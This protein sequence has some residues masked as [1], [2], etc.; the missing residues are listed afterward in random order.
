LVTAAESTV[1]E[2]SAAAPQLVYPLSSEEIARAKA[3]ETAHMAELL[4]QPGVQGVGISSS[5]DSAGE[6]ALLIYFIRGVEHG[7]VPQ[8]IDG[9]RTRVREGSRFRGDYGG[10]RPKRGCSVPA[11]KTAQAGT[12]SIT[13][14]KL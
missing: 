7:A 14:P 13:K 11:P 5:A 9:L 8:V 6:A 12:A 1:L 3:V 10:V 2:K 4:K